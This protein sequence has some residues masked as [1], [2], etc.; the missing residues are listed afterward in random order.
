MTDSTDTIPSHAT[1]SIALDHPQAPPATTIAGKFW[2]PETMRFGATFFGRIMRALHRSRRR[3]ARRVIR[4]HQHLIDAARMRPLVTDAARS[5]TEGTHLSM[6]S[7]TSGRLAAAWRGVMAPPRT[8]E[9]TR[10]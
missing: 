9:Q 7:E 3:H 5:P 6:R 1:P 4:E 2:S 10:S 8:S